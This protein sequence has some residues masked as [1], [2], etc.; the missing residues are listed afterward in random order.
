MRTTFCCR[1]AGAKRCSGHGDLRK[2]EKA[3]LA[4]RERV[5]AAETALA[6]AKNEQ[7]ELSRRRKRLS[8]E[9]LQH[10]QEFERLWAEEAAQAPKGVDSDS[11]A[12]AAQE[13]AETAP[14][15]R[16]TV[17]IATEEEQQ[18]QQAWGARFA[19]TRSCLERFAP[20]AP[21]EGAER[22]DG[23]SEL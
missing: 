16:K 10:A 2:A 17:R 15:R 4:Q 20:E 1:Q 23:G 11:D 7:Q 18:E 22:T 3:L 8:L 9:V 6:T 13:G 12:E 5:I 19:E 14:K 21:V